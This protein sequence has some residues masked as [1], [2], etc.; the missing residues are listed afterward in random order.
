MYK[1]ECGKEFDHYQ[2]FNGHKSRCKIHY[3]ALGKLDKLNEYNIKRSNTLSKVLKGKKKNNFEPYKCEKCGKLVTEKYGSGRFCSRSCANLRDLSNDTKNKIS[4]HM[5]QKYK[6]KNYK[7]W[8][9]KMSTKA[10]KLSHERKMKRFVK[11]RN[12]QILDITNEQLEEYRK[13]HFVCEIC[14]QIERASHNKHNVS[15]L[16]ADHDHETCKFRGLLCSNCN[17][18]LGWF[19]NYKDKILNYL[20][21]SA[22]S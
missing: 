13:T 7:S 8:M 18:K 9:I 2:K 10:G 14:G 6:D 5:I 17:R 21:K 3:K 1:C 4:N 16:C 20:N 11:C 12:G 22:C 15:K 19:E